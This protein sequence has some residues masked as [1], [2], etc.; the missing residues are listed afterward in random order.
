MSKKVAPLVKEWVD[1]LLFANYKTLVYA[2]D[3]KGKK[4]KASGGQRV[5]YTAHHPCWD[6]KNRH[7]LPEEMPF[8]FGQVA[9]L[10][11]PIN[12]GTVSSGAEQAV[13]PIPTNAQQEDPFDDPVPAT[14]DPDEKNIPEKLRQ[15]MDADGIKPIEVKAAIAQRGYFP[16]STKWISFPED[17]VKGVL[18]GAW[19]Q[20]K[21]MCLTNREEAPF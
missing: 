15:L 16:M 17:F 7:G 9:H 4:H 3:D 1:I 12:S 10:F 8:D 18:I 11:A 14:E 21:Q 20:V 2:T 13:Q 6:A 19:P 5:M